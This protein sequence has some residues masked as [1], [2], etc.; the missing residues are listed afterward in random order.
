MPMTTFLHLLRRRTGGERGFAMVSALLAVVVA[1]IL[2]VT[3]MQLSLHTQQTSSYERA[4]TQAIHAAEAGLDIA[5]EQFEDTA[6]GALPCAISGSLT[7]TPVASWAVEITYYPAYP[8]VDAPLTC[9]DD[10]LSTSLDPGGAAITA[11]GSVE[12]G[13]SGTVERYMETQVQ[14]SPVYGAFNK[15]IFSDETPEI[16]S[17]ITVYGENGNDADFLTNS[18][19]TCQNSLTVYGSIYI[20]GTAALNNSCRTLVDLWALDSI[21]MAQSSRVDHN[22]ISSNG[23]LTMSN[24]SHVGNNAVIAGGTCPGCSTRVGGGITTGYSQGPPPSIT[25]PEMTFD[26]QAWIDE[27]WTIEYFTDCDAAR[28]WITSGSNSAVKGV[29]RI[30]GG[31]TLSFSQHTTVTRTADLAVFT[32]GEITTANNTSFVTGDSAWHN[33]YLIV[34]TAASCQGSDG[35]ITMSNLTSFTKEYFFVFSPCGASFA[36]NNST[37][38]GQIYGGT[39]TLSNNL[40]Y[41][42]HAMLVPGA[43]DI[44]AYEAKVAFKREIN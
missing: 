21:T 12:D 3:V 39:V 18:D 43:G 41:T 29:V 4:R 44:T 34:E 11:T 20:Q 10:Y 38:R 33:L 37:A 13:V 15:A 1:S 5:L 19:W 26:D 22:A 16:T 35:E 24:N 7:A 32:D 30:T 36:N 40:T 25:F 23:G 2:G 42:F 9:T 8:L 31:C 6:T 14:L 27:S 17:N 28:D